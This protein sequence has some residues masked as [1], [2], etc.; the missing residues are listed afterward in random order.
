[1][2]IYLSDK[3]LSLPFEYGE[4]SRHRIRVYCATIYGI[5]VTEEQCKMISKAYQEKSRVALKME[6]TTT[7]GLDFSNVSNFT[8]GNISS[9]PVSV[10]S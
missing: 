9:L 4:E 6:D 5:A 8:I 2:K 1:M 3:H 7:M 10:L